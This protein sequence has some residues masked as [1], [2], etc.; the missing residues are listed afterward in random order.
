M[1]N[2]LSLQV[3]HGRYQVLADL[4]LHITPCKEDEK[5][6]CQKEIVIKC[7]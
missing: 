7:R 1:F 3:P 5:K 4:S 6:G 2:D